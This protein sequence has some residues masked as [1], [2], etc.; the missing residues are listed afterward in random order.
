MWFEAKFGEPYP[1]LLRTAEALERFASPMFAVG[2]RLEPDDRLHIESP[3]DLVDL[4]ALR[5]RPN[6]RRNTIHFART[7]TDVQ[8][9]L[10]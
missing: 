8:R 5:L 6:P 10:A 1:P 3:F 9:P 4:F 2:I 7:S